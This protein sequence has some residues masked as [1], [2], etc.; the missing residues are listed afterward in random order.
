MDN[1]NKFIL[2]KCEVISGMV[3]PL[4]GVGHRSALVGRLVGDEMALSANSDSQEADLP[5]TEDHT[6]PSDDDQPLAGTIIPPDS[7]V[8]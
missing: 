1:L 3:H 2:R 8:E 4:R 6:G 5:T 7:S